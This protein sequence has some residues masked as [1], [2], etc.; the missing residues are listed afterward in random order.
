MDYGLTITQLLLPVTGHRV[1]PLAL[2]KDRY[3]AQSSL[4]NF[5]NEKTT[6]GVVG[7]VGL[8]LL[9]VPIVQPGVLRKLP[10]FFR[11][12]SPLNFWAIL[13]ATM[14]GVGSLFAFVVTPM[15]RGYNRISVFI[16]FFCLLA[17]AG[18]LD[19]LAR[20]FPVLAGRRQYALC[21]GL[22][23]FGIWDQTTA[24]MV[25][26]YEGI[27]ERRGQDRA[28]IN[29]IEKEL[30][31]GAMVFQL[32]YLRFPEN[33][34][35]FDML[36]YSHARGYLH[37][38]SLRWSYGAL[39]WSWHGEWQDEI[40]RKPHTEMVRDLTL[41]GFQGIYVDRFGYTGRG[42]EMVKELSSALGTEPVVSPN[43]RFVFYNLLEFEKRLRTELSPQQ[44]AEERQRV[45]PDVRATWGNGF[46]GWERG[47]NRKWRWCDSQ[48]SLVLENLE[49]EPRWVEMEMLLRPGQ[50]STANLDIDSGLFSARLSIESSGTNFRRIFSLP[51]GKH[52]V[53]LMSD[54]DRVIAPADPRRLVFSVEA[55]QLR[56]LP[57]DEAAASVVT[58]SWPAGFYDLETNGG[59]EWRWCGRR[60]TLLLLNLSGRKKEIEVDML[61][62]AGQDAGANLRIESP[63]LSEDIRITPAGTK[64]NRVLTVEPGENPIVFECD[65]SPFG[66]AN[67]PRELVFRIDDFRIRMLEGDPK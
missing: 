45:L 22:L 51:S 36:D 56:P 7:G 59:Q 38:R 54:G 42:D 61:V 47:E 44:W 29:R 2:F 33:G 55:F 66:A 23:V 60:G 16:G 35:I 30:P 50:D 14:G 8:L 1:L 3:N 48:G 26:D 62:R 58:A 41:A 11:S 65:G 32:P 12:I 6:L 5:G 15:M 17:V 43:Q 9:L 39:K 13:I 31:N 37:S 10:S 28:F 21:G 27:R 24:R 52:H 46:W 53:K 49:D 57:P 19:A 64:F 63:I 4:V 20:R 40:S 25:P 18:V 67:D 34:P